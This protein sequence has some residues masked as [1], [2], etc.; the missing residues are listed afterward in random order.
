MASIF[1]N[2]TDTLE[3]FRTKTNTLSGGVGDLTTLTQDATVTY[4]GQDGIN[5]D[6]FTGTPA[7]FD[8]SRKGGSYTVEVNTGGSGYAVNDTILVKGS[9]LG[10]EDGTNDATIT[11]DAVSGSFAVTEASIAGTAVADI[12]SEVNKIRDEM[13]LAFNDL[14][15]NA[16]NIG[17]A[18]NEIYDVLAAATIE[19]QNY[20]LN[21]DADN[22]V[23]AI[24]EI[25]TAVRGTNTDYDLDTTAD[26]LV[27]AVN[28]H[29][30]D[31]GSMS[32]SATGT[33]SNSLVDYV[34]IGSDVTSALNALKA[35]S[36]FHS[37]Q[38]GGVMAD[39]YDG[40][41]DDIIAA[42]NQLYNRSDLG[43]LDNTYVARDG[44]T[45]MTDML[46]IDGNGITSNSENYLIKTGASDTTR[47]TISAA[48]G[49]VGIGGAVGT[50]KLKVT[51]G[52]NATTGFYYNGDDTDTRY[53]R[54]DTGSAQTL[55]IATTVTGDLTLS[56]ASGKS[57]VI[58]GSTVATDS[59]TYLEW[60]QDTVGAMFTGNSESGGISG[61][62]ND[63][64][65]KITLAIANNSHSHLNTNISN[66]DEAV[67]DTVGAM[68]GGNTENGIAVTYDDNSGKLNF[69]VNDPVLTI[70]GEA[71]GSATMTNLGDTTVSI[72]L[73]DEAI[74][75]AAAAMLTNGTHTGISTTYDDANNKLN[76]ALTKDP[77]ITLTGD[78]SGSGTMVD[79]S[80]V[81]IAVTVADD[82][83]NHVVGN[84]D[85][86]TENVQDIVG[87]MVSNNSESGISVTYNDSQGELDFDVND[88]TITLT[89]DVSGSAQMTNLGSVSIACTVTNDSHNHDGRYYTETEAD[90]RFANVSG[91]TFTGNVTIQDSNLYVQRDLYI[92]ENG[93]GNSDMYFYDDNSDTWRGLRW[94]DGT[95]DWEVEANNGTYYR[96]IHTG[97]Q[98]SFTVSNATNASTLDSLDSSQFLRSD[99][100]D[101][102]TG[103][104]TCS[105]IYTRSAGTYDI[106]ASGTRWRTMY[107]TT[108]NG[109]ATSARYADLAEKYLADKEYRVGTVVKVGGEKE[110]TASTSG[111][112][113]IGV[114][115]ENPAFMMNRDLE[116]GTYIAL[117]GRVPV[118]CMG[119]VS[120]GDEM[121]ATNDG[122]AFPGEGKVFAVALEDKPGVE[123]G[124]VECVIL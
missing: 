78:V 106:G 19:V 82:S 56:P 69:N 90:N 101:T 87:A 15:T 20:S 53:V 121:V 95:N 64:D 60:F 73:S 6:D 36:D 23:A 118:R 3:N 30:A 94:A 48:N 76:L 111:S 65:G 83:H 16:N 70:S 119:P 97:N 35:K 45:P 79:L 89:G 112:R 96:L 75:D 114:V 66:W 26:N 2:K 63:T 77:T 57:V 122:L 52:I 31:L 72:T 4:S 28:E 58:A 43:T 92:G 1:V 32:F 67:Q 107:A 22:I 85:N 29:E 47:I 102:A 105:H 50:Q 108:F 124:L 61:V 33:S 38:I 59:L 104:L 68:V 49:N 74:Q 27:S 109:T 46:V 40:A 39:D 117:K 9:E 80:N 34:N 55:E 10:G 24:N 116:G 41:T 17:D 115:S 25:E 71:T 103:N 7:T 88:P 42:L 81:S 37:D 13:G 110:V 11:V 120:K 86:F 99:A 98:S 93:A 113:A 100:N 8:V 12:V 91:D 51:G 14:D 44:S 84:I 54:T 62:Y 18:I 123:E 5:A 21:T